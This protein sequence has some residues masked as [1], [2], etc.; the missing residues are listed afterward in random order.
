[1]NT[2]TMYLI[3]ALGTLMFFSRCKREEDIKKEG[4]KLG[5]I[6]LSVSEQNTVPYQINDTIIFKDSLENTKMFIVKSREVY[7]P[8]VYKDAGTDSFTDYYDVEQLHV[9]LSNTDMFE[10]MVNLRAPLPTYCSPLNSGKNFFHISFATGGVSQTHSF[11]L[12]HIDPTAFYYTDEGMSIPYHSSITFSGHTFNAVYELTDINPS[13]TNDYVQTVYY[14]VSEGII[15]Y[16]TK[17]GAEWY[18]YN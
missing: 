17:A 3:L 6:R 9:E 14:S 18:L 8:R 11:F 7:S 2:K 1:M 16:R 4:A 15:G 10:I 12:S 13:T 5:D